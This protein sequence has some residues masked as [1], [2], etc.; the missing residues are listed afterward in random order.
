MAFRA[1]VLCEP[2]IA[3]IS[4]QFNLSD[5][6]KRDQ[7]LESHALR[8]G[9]QTQQCAFICK[10]GMAQRNWHIEVTLPIV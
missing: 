8:N 1:S 3:Y 7:K 10:W 4:F 9:E 2:S 5:Q 6:I